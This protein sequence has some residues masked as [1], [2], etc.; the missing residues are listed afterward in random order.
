MLCH[1]TV[2]VKSGRN[3][4]LNIEIPLSNLAYP[5]EETI[6]GNQ[7]EATEGHSMAPVAA[8]LGVHRNLSNLELKWE[9]LPI[10]PPR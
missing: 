3:N 9:L 8:A 2:H 6:M 10:A 1:Q 4:N 7:V 5:K